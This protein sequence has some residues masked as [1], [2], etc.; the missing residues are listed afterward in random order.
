MSGDHTPSSLPLRLRILVVEDEVLIRMLFEDMLDE[1]GHEI[2]GSVGTIDDALSHAR[3]S[4]CDLA[5]LDVHLNGIHVFPAA[6]VLEE[7]RIP[8][9]FATGLSDA[10]LPDKY[11]GRP[12]IQKPF[13]PDLLRQMLAQAMAAPR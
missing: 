3:S 12:T 2:E 7:R 10:S 4:T 6:D 13:Q 1:L 8:F 9:I 5:I 11:R